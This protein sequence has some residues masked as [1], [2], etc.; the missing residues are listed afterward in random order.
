MKNRIEQL[1]GTIR[2]CSENDL[3]F[4]TLKTLKMIDDE[5][6]RMQAELDRRRNLLEDVINALDLSD[7]I[8]ETHGPMGTAPAVLVR[9]VL[10]QKDKQIQLLKAGWCNCSH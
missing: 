10:G 3:C 7:G 5:A 4:G 1:T 9:L 8:I 2:A 6:V